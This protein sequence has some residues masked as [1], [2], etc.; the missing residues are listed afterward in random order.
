[1]KRY[2]LHNCCR[3]PGK[4]LRT[5][6]YSQNFIRIS[7]FYYFLHIFYSYLFWWNI[8]LLFSTYFTL[9]KDFV[10]ILEGKRKSFMQNNKKVNS[11]YHISVAVCLHQTEYI[12]TEIGS[13]M[14][15]G[16]SPHGSQQT[17]HEHF[18]S[19]HNFGD[20]CTL[21]FFN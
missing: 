8:F 12:K 10:E 17:S 3:K 5:S 16:T 1:M 15:G 19:W 11:R 14:K 13:D 9:A 6:K 2:V 21:F 18:C 20:E 4:W 7:I